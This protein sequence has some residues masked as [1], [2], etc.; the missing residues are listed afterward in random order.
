MECSEVQC[1]VCSPL[2]REY[3]IES[4]LSIL[5]YFVDGVNKTVFLKS[6]SLEADQST[7]KSFEIPNIE[8]F[9]YG[10]L[11]NGYYLCRHCKSVFTFLHCEDTLLFGKSEYVKVE[12]SD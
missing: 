8:A 3:D 12:N 9:S 1:N 6:D 10:E 7:Y 11:A 2:V 5:P 4:F